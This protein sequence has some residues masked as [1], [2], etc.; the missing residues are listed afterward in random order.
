MANRTALNPDLVVP[1]LR[2]AFRSHGSSVV[3][4]VADDDCG[5]FRI[6]RQ[7]IVVSADFLNATPIAEQLGLADEFGLGRLAVAATLSDLLGSGALPSAL[8]IGVTVPHGYPTSRFKRMMLGVR[9]EAAKWRVHV[10]SGDT[11]LGHGR[12]I[13][14][15]GIGTVRSRRELFL[16]VQAKPGDHIVSS[17]SLGSCA[18]ATLLA[19][20]VNKKRLPAWARSAILE[21]ALPMRQ[22]RQLARLRVAHGGIDLTDGLAKDLRSLCAASSVGAELYAGAIPVS[23]QVSEL[24]HDLRVEPWAFALASGG[25]FQFLAT[26]P[27]RTLDKVLSLGFHVIGRITKERRMRLRHLGGRLVPLPNVGHRDRRGQRFVDEILSIVKEV[28]R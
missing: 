7:L 10:V 19:G 26:V 18:A 12:A 2:M 6:G 15:C 28:G 1:W 13:L 14:T 22:S 25:D 5:V 11:K 8:V 20:Q 27:D 4:G 9:F 17:G 21:P 24:A 23:P 3:A 16:T